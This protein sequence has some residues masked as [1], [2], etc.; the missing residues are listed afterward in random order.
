MLMCKQSAVAGIILQ[1]PHAV[2]IVRSL[3]SLIC[4]L[5]PCA[6]RRREFGIIF[7]FLFVILCILCMCVM[8]FLLV[9]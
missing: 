6:H 3:L 5:C 4:M 8:V 9:C 7:P 2:A 1:A